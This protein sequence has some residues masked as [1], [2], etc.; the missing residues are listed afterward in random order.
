M[1]KIS[2]RKWY[3]RKQKGINVSSK[4]DELDLLGDE[5]ESFTGTNADLE[6]AADN[7]F[8][9]PPR[10]QP[11]PFSSLSI[12]PPA[13]TV[14]PTPGAAL[15]QKIEL[16][17]E[18]SLGNTLNLHLQKQMGSFQAS[19][20]IWKWTMVQLLLQVSDLSIR[21]PRIRTLMHSRNLLRRSQIDPKCTFTLIASKMLIRGLSWMHILM[22]L[23]NLGFHLPNLK[24]MLTRA[25]IKLG[26]DISHY[27]QRKIS[28]LW[29]NNG[30]LSP[31]G[32][33]HL[34]LTLTKTN[35]NMIQALLTI[36]K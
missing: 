33:A 31:L 9:S 5:V 23:T 3:I 24:N 19:P 32:L 1:N 8:T 12:K 2:Q 27:L 25:S 26:P 34:G 30:L 29:L 36:G 4:D 16:N 6:S 22:N 35:L 17:L 21:M 14:P 28:L 18:K 15:Q 10:P 11:L 7:L 20:R 13:K